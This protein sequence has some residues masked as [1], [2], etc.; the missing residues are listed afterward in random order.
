MFYVIFLGLYVLAAWS[1]VEHGVMDMIYHPNGNG[2]GNG[3][4]IGNASFIWNWCI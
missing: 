2:N 3:V 4:G 1:S